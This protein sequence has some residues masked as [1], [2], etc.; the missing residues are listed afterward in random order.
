M[1]LV[2]LL[3]A[4]SVAG[5]PVGN[6]E[7]LS[8]RLD[9]NLAQLLP[10]R[11]L[12]EVKGSLGHSLVELEPDTKAV[13][14]SVYLIVTAREAGQSAWQSVICNFDAGG[15]LTRCVNEG[16][17]YV[18]QN[19]AEADWDRIAKGASLQTVY[20]TIGPPGE[21]VLGTPPGNDVGLEYMVT[22]SK[23][24]PQFSTCAGRI[25]VKRGVVAA[26]ELMCE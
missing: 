22:L 4:G 12:A 25:L 24:T 16:P 3:I 11:T 6:S 21:P 2:A 23:S 9:A 26:K 7:S 13:A 17:R 19:V 8:Q 18:S 10:G 14:R 15:R 20:R 1:I 5:E